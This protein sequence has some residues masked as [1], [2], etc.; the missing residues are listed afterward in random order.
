MEKII[1]YII[2]LTHLYGLVHKNKV[3]EI[4]NQQNKEKVELD[5]IEAII[6]EKRQYLLSNEYIT[7]HN[8]YFVYISIMVSDNFLKELELRKDK[9]YYTP[10]KDELL[11]Y[12]DT[13]YFEVN[14]E[15]EELL[16]FLKKIYWRKTKAE[17]VCREIK[18]ICKSLKSIENLPLFIERWRIPMKNEKQLDEFIR[19]VTDLANNTRVWENNGFTPNELAKFI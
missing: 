8:N 10:N 11:K 5:C 4:Y 18:Y 17:N 19:L 1:E 2:S 9:P 6:K 14:K 15:Y 3:I 7:I 16:G 13:N 12:I